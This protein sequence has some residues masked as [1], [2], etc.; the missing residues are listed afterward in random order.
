MHKHKENWVDTFLC[1]YE[2]GIYLGNEH[3]LHRV[4]L[5][6]LQKTTT[7]NDVYYDECQFSS[8]RRP[9]ES[10]RVVEERDETTEEERTSKET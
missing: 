9:I 2:K 1:K 3:R 6:E 4:Y 8:L 7:T 5:D 10:P